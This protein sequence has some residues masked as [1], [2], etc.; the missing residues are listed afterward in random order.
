MDNLPTGHSISFPLKTKMLFYLTNQLLVA[1][2]TPDYVDVISA[3]CNIAVSVYEHK[4]EL[5]GDYDI[6][7][8][9]S[10]CEALDHRSRNVI[11]Q[12][13]SN[14]ET[15]P[16]PREI[17][18]YVEVV[19]N[20][21][22]RKRIAGNCVIT[23]IEYK[24]LMDSK[25]TQAT[26]LVGEFYYD[27]EF[28]RY[29]LN[30]YK[31]EHHFDKVGTTFEDVSGS[32]SSTIDHV[33]QYLKRD[34]RPT[35]CIVDTDKKY[36][37]QPIQYSSTCGK[38]MN[39]YVENVIYRFIHLNVQ[40]VENLV[41][42]DVVDA[43]NWS[44]A[45]VGFKK[46]F[47]TLRGHDNSE[48]LLAYF[49]VKNGIKKDE[50]FLKNSDYRAYAEACCSCDPSNPASVDFMSYSNSLPLKGNLFPMLSNNLLKDANEYL[51]NNADIKFTLLEF[52]KKEWMKIA[53]SMLNWGVCRNKEGL[54]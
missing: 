20:I 37:S 42:L 10:S 30:W 26:C 40:E 22:T 18:Y 41:P 24:E 16:I 8:K 3:I 7:K 48:E 6:L 33:K 46:S 34:K 11:Y 39:K 15:M 1:E 12:V 38:C 49:D 21:S 28:Y 13:Y 45:G 36:P 4:H 27:C 44:G 5:R 14:Y 32:G 23:Q 47:D 53:R 2:G 25:S 19:Y 52:Q 29:I 54:N 17:T 9:M 35:I 43:L 50:L 51:R 31:N